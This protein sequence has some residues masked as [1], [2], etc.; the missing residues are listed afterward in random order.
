MFLSFTLNTI[1]KRVVP[2]RKR[3]ARSLGAGPCGRDG[4]AEPQAS[5][6]PPSVCSPQ[7]SR[8]E[9]EQEG[10]KRYEA[11]KLERMET[12]WRNGDIVQPVLNP[13]E[14]GGRCA[15]VALG[16]GHHADP[17][18]PPRLTR[19]AGR[20][21]RPLEAWCA[22]PV[23]A[24]VRPGAKG[25]ACVRPAR[26]PGGG[27]PVHR[28]WAL[29]GVPKFTQERVCDEI[30]TSPACPPSRRRGEQTGRVGRKAVRGASSSLSVI[31][32]GPALR[33]HQIQTGS[34]MLFPQRGL[35]LR[36]PDAGPPGADAAWGGDS[37]RLFPPGLGEPWEGSPGAARHPSPV[38]RDHAS[39]VRAAPGRMLCASA[40]VWQR[41]LLC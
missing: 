22:P 5:A 3:R 2:V 25:V 32:G 15:D 24:R 18:P 6:D 11:Q 39:S 1:R 34:G 26:C 38:C 21:G 30:S 17:F 14:S 33:K 31:Q 13:G 35:F 10:R 7:Y 29:W 4:G 20:L 41:R 23:G 16:P 27:T 36:V 8:Q 12:K 28:D 19:M 40:S 37:G 9:Q